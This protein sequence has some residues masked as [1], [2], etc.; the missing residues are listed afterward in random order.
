MTEKL[1]S[2]DI[3]FDGVLSFFF[4]QVD[5]L[6]QMDDDLKFKARDNKELTSQVTTEFY[7]HKPN[8]PIY[9]IMDDL[10]FTD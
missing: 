3:N 9:R 7:R 1:S 4:S 2:Q 5:Q 10:A 8:V 6:R